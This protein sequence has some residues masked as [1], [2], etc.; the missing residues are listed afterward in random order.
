[1]SRHELFIL[2]VSFYRFLLYFTSYS[3]LDSMLS[4]SF[5][6]VIKPIKMAENITIMELVHNQSSVRPLYEK[7]WIVDKG[8]PTPLP[9]L[10]THKTKTKKHTRHICASQY[11]K[12]WLV[13]RMWN[14]K[15]YFWP[16]LLFSNKHEV[17]N[18]QGFSD[19]NL[20]QARNSKNIQNHTRM[21]N[22]I[23]SQHYWKATKW[24]APPHSIQ[25]RRQQAQWKREEQI[26]I[27]L[28]YWRCLLLN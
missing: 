21:C 24:P 8:R 15:L 23:Y 7:L 4:P 27:T 19:I 10:I 2:I 26:T 9:N 22:V 12:G 11:H 14:N 3:Y 25:K 5:Y 13:S 1:M 20:F 28:I 6:N 17:R 16:C 18:K